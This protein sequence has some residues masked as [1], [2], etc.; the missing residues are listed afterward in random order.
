MINKTIVSVIRQS[1]LQNKEFLLAS[2]RM[3]RLNYPHSYTGT[4]SA[5]TNIP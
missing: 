5:L 4:N 2:R 3:S 1:S